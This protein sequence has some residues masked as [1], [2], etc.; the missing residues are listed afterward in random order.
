MQMDSK[1]IKVALYVSPEERKLLVVV[2]I[3]C[4]QKT[5]VSAYR[6]LLAFGW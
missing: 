6:M 5:D 2:S 4:T 1:V 3:F